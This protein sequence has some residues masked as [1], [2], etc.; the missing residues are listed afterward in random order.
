MLQE[1]LDL[2]TAISASQAEASVSLYNNFQIYI[3]IRKRQFALFYIETTDG[4]RAFFGG[5]DV[6]DS[7][8]TE[9]SWGCLEGVVSVNL[10]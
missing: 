3:V 10:N 6:P 9:R 1:Q 8:R 2:C 5:R 4:R 7:L